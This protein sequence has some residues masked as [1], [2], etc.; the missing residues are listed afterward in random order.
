MRKN[1]LWRAFILV[2]VLGLCL[3][4][5]FPIDKSFSKG[6]DLAGGTQFTIM[7]LLDGIPEEDRNDKMNSILAVYRSRIDEIGI[8]GTT[9][10]QA[11][12]NRIIVQV[13]GI[14]TEETKRVR[15]ILERTAYLEFKL[16]VDGP[17]R[18][19]ALN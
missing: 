11:G 17:G 7:V 18:P 19:R 4:L 12:K 8:A 14:D 10:E 2:M 3:Y 16:V 1:L 6:I 5:I 15:G 13:P 9:V